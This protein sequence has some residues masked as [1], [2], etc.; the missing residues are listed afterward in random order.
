MASRTASPAA[1]RR[2]N[3]LS[4][5]EQAG[6][7]W[8]DFLAITFLLDPRLDNPEGTRGL[9]PYALFQPDRTQ[10]TACGRGRTRATWTTQPFTYDSIKTNGWLNGTSLA[11]PHGL[12]HGWAAV[13]VGH[14]VGPD[15]QAR[16]QPEP[17]R[18]PGTRAATTAR[19]ST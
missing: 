5:N 17:V 9:V 16:V 10:A 7:G 19:S 4:G 1:R 8:S 12:G 3:C 2:Q 18:R 13:A 11:L 15:R 14:D 6:E